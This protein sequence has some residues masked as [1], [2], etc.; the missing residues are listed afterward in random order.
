MEVKTKVGIQIEVRANGS[1]KIM[2]F[3]KPIR[4]I[5]LTND[6]SAHI[7]TLFNGHENWD[8]L[9]IEKTCHWE[10]LLFT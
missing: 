8:Y 6:E 2:S 9:R 3:N 1:S 5:E 4:S 7:G 10:V